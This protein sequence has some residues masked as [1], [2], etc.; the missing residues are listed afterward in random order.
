MLLYNKY[1]EYLKNKYGTKVYKLPINIPVSCPNR[2]GTI[3]NKGCIFCGEEGAGFEALSNN[4]SVRE[5][6][7]IN[8]KYI[9]ENYH[10]QKFIAY[11]QNYTNTYLPFNKFKEFISQALVEDIV[12]IYISTRPDCIPNEHLEFLQQLQVQNK[13]DIIM[14]VGLQTINNKTLKILNRGHTLED[15]IDA[16]KRIKTKEI[17]LCA[18]YIVDLPWDSLNDVIEGAKILT[19]LEIDQVKI[20]SLYILEGTEL[21]RMYQNKE[22]EPLPLQQYIQRV[23]AFLEHLSPQIVIQRLIGRAPKER[24]LFCNWG[25]S[26]WKIKDMV[27][28]IMTQNGFYQGRLV[29]K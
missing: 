26:W 19:S 27:E 23:I 10:A 25:M 16:A 8:M 7:Q 21:G 5:Q 11:F 2:D 24:T 1:S 29:G 9:K 17:G 18:H 12:G 22:F 20:H 15:F 3:S 14:E 28:E 13:I 6:I 4:L